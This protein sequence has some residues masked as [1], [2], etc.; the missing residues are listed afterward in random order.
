[1]ASSDLRLNHYEKAIL[2][3]LLYSDIF[4]F[5]LTKDELWKFLVSKSRI[6]KKTFEEALLSLKLTITQKDGY[7]SLAG[8]GKNIT[9]RKQY[10]SQVAQKKHI[11]KKAAYYL[12]YVP[13]I[14]FIGISGGL[15]IG[16][17]ERGDDIDLFLITKKHT[18]FVTRLFVLA[19]LE[20]MNLRRRRNEKNPN[21]KVCTNLIIEETRL[22]WPEKQRDIYTAHEIAQVLPLFEREEM[23]QKFLDSN[24]WIE[25][26]LPNCLSEKGEVIGKKWKR[27]YYSLSL[28]SLL[29]ASSPIERFVRN[30]QKR[31]MKRHQ[32]TETVKE[33]VLA[34]HPNDYRSKIVSI[35]NLKLKQF[36][37]LTKI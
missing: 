10:L 5:P 34:L 37:L 27:Q 26:F 19:I 3:T 6:S 9:R 24:S 2:L 13:T 4:D 18:L 8:K 33:N 28:I 12:S 17:A 15:A 1:M 29:L 25:S 32:T 14:K 21:N 36:G 31:Y 35:L 11:A 22:R 23:Y 7:Y 20:L 30:L 16:D